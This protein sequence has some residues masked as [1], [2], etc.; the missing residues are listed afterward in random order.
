MED[1]LPYLNTQFRG[2]P[3]D[4]QTRRVTRQS[5]LSERWGLTPG[6]LGRHDPAI[7]K[8]TFTIRKPGLSIAASQWEPYARAAPG[9][10][11]SRHEAPIRV[12]VNA[13]IA[14]IESRF[15]RNFRVLQTETNTLRDMVENLTNVIKDLSLRLEQQSASQRDSAAGTEKKEPLEVDLDLARMRARSATL[16][17]ERFMEDARQGRPPNLFSDIPISFAVQSPFA[18]NE[19]RHQEEDTWSKPPEIPKAPEPEPEPEP[20]PKPKP[21]VET[22]IQ[23]SFL[24]L[25]KALLDFSTSSSLQLSSPL[26]PGAE[27]EAF[28]APDIWNNLRTEQRSHRVMAKIFQI[29]WNDILRPGLLSF[30]LDGLRLNQEDRT[31]SQPEKHLR[32]LEQELVDLGDSVLQPW[33]R[34]TI[35]TTARLRNLTQSLAPTTST[36]F[37]ALC[38]VLQFVF[39]RNAEQWV[40]ESGWGAVAQD[41][42]RGRGE[43]I[44]FRPWAEEKLKSKRGKKSSFSKDD[45]DNDKPQESI[46]PKPPPKPTVDDVPDS[47]PKPRQ[48]S[49]QLPTKSLPKVA[50]Q[51]PAVPSKTEEPTK[52]RVLTL[53]EIAR[54]RK[55]FAAQKNAQRAEEEKQKSSELP[56]TVS[57]EPPPSEIPLNT[58]EEQP[59]LFPTDETMDKTK[60]TRKK[61]L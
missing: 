4:Y 45:Q 6:T 27:S 2:F 32:I 52:P 16:E 60:I 3:L 7:R 47:A 43:S 14:A 5:F 26:L 17:A 12:P 56:I 61:F 38:P 1:L 28:C 44:L 58:A 50:R 22:R 24:A 51:K 57:T 18:S 13:V 15:H 37:T 20:E 9:T 49:P 42:T 55:R 21:E 25:R 19:M 11:I 35:S 31:V 39:A 36:I 46:R 48:R 59:L 8:S 23:T 54:E 40:V 34:S 33:R 41:G 53:P 10:G 30:G 29:L